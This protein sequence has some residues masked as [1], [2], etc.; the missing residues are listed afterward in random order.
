M[1]SK[2]C[3]MSKP[4]ACI[5]LQVHKGRKNC[6]E[7]YTDSKLPRQRKIIFQQQGWSNLRYQDGPCKTNWM[8]ECQKVHTLLSLEARDNQIT[9][10]LI[11]QWNPAKHRTVFCMSSSSALRVSLC[12]AFPVLSVGLCQVS[13]SFFEEPFECC[14]WKNRFSPPDGTC[15]NKPSLPNHGL[16]LKACQQRE[17]LSDLLM[18]PGL[19]EGK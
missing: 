16:W 14:R 18:G 9:E 10:I 1:I 12:P 15:T 3:Q 6:H 4:S 11:L 2:V 19:L 17:G 13:S 7:K 8:K 5:S